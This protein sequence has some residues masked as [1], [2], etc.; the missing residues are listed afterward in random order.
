MN[1]TRHYQEGITGD[2]YTIRY[3]HDAD[4]WHALAEDYPDNPF[5]NCP[6]K[7]HISPTGE[8]SLPCHKF[9]PPTFEALQS[10]VVLWISAYSKYVRTGCFAVTGGFVTT[11]LR[12][13]LSVSHS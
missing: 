3:R 4:G 12:A 6:M 10:I 7:C 9:M 2:S 13:K 1:I 5:D 8:I 11:G